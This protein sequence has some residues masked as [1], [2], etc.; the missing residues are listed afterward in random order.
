MKV[1]QI[2]IILGLQIT[3][4][5]LLLP[6][7]VFGTNSPENFTI[8][9]QFPLWKNSD[10]NNLIIKQ[11]VNKTTYHTW[12]TIP[13]TQEL[14]NN[15]THAVTMRHYV[16]W[17]HMEVTYP[18]G[19]VWPGMLIGTP[20]IEPTNS[21]TL[22]PGEHL[23]VEASLPDQPLQ[24]GGTGKYNIT[25]FALFSTP[26]N[27]TQMLLRSDPLQITVVPEFGS[28]ASLITAVSIIGILMISKIFRP[29]LSQNNSTK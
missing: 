22:E 7:I 25:S 2:S 27:Y 3:F 19:V 21:N 23:N 24:F 15:G 28:L 14:I 8:E 4:I 20:L 5:V 6:Q 11:I 26:N 29:Y 16:G 17:I 13:I 18:N 9:K 1:L 12:E 10:G